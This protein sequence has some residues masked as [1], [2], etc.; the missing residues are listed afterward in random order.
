M[1]RLFT[2]LFVRTIAKPLRQLPPSEA[3]NPPSFPQRAQRSKKFEIRSRLKISIENEIFER[4][5]HRGPT[6]CGEIKTSRLTF[7]SEI[8]NFDRDWKFRSRS[9][10]FYRWALWVLNKECSAQIAQ[11]IPH[12]GIVWAFKGYVFAVLGNFCF[13]LRLEGCGPQGLYNHFK[14]FVAQSR[15]QTI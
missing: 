11:N 9:N 14:L 15:S 2:T 8:K 13:L 10:F 7:S 6:F 12:Q 5:T 3:K 4:A 1:S